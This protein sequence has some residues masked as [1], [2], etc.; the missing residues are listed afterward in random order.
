M[1]GGDIQHR[2]PGIGAADIARQYSHS[3]S[4]W[5][6]F[7]LQPNVTVFCRASDSVARIPAARRAATLQAAANW[8]NLPRFPV[9]GAGGH[10]PD[11]A[12]VRA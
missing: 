1:T 5:L 8:Y 6:L 10:S 2:Q 12:A 9:A 4:L 11:W 3:R 7:A